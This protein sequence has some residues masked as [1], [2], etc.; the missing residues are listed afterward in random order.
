MQVLIYDESWAGFLTA[1]FEIYDR[2]IYTVNITSAKRYI[3]G[4]FESPILVVTDDSKADRVWSGLSKKVSAQALRKLYA[5]YLSELPDIENTLHEYIRLVFKMSRSPE[6]AYGQAA[7][8]KVSQVDKM[9]HREKHRMEAFVRFQLTSDHLYYAGVEPDFNVLPL[10]LNHFKRRYADQR[11]LIYDLK[12]NYGIYY[13]LDIVDEVVLHPADSI[14][15]NRMSKNVFHEDE[16]IYQTLWKDYFKHVN[17]SERKNNK[18]HMQHVPKRY[19]KHLTEKK[20][21]IL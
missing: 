4:I 8:L 14:Q 1:I 20:T 11:W 5:C 21:G 3:P 15:V 6:S 9:V 19:W 17:I 2:G 16:E 18:L 10:I 7:V 12:R 13:D